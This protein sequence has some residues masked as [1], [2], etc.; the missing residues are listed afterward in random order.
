M[1]NSQARLIFNVL[2]AQ[3]EQEIATT[4][5]VLAAVPA[6]KEDYRPHPVSKSALDLAWHLATS[7]YWFLASI[8]RGQFIAEEAR[9]PEGVRSAPD[10]VAWYD[11]NVPPLIER[12]K[13]LPDEELARIVPMFD[14]MRLPAV[15]YL[16]VMMLHAAHHRGQLSAYLRPM[17]G[18]VP[19]IYG[20]SADEQPSSTA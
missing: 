15:Q 4:R 5:R 19:A 6:G 12:L 18:R 3:L 10:V 7:D 2:M 14:I 9:L 20:A 8:A 13:T 16:L 1:E 17:G 11:R